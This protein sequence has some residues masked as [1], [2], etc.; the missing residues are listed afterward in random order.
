ML[1]KTRKTNPVTSSQS[2][3]SIRPKTPPVARPARMTALNVRLRLA[4]WA[5]IRAAM[6]IFRAVEMLITLR[7]YQCS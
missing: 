5:A 3:C 6:L 7:F 2:W 1:A 4:C